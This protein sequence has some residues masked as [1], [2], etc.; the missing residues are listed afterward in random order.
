MQLKKRKQA[1]LRLY[2]KMQQ[3]QFEIASDQAELDSSFRTIT[4]EDLD[5]V[6]HVQTTEE[7]RDMYQM[8]VLYYGR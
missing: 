3:Y 2:E 1:L 7:L 6:R 8:L 4:E 5:K